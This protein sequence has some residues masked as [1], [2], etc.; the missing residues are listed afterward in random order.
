M[1]DLIVARRARAPLSATVPIAVADE[2]V[3]KATR[4]RARNRP[5]VWL[6]RSLLGVPFVFMG[7]ELVS[8]ALDPA[9]GVPLVADSANDVLGTSA[10]ILFVLMLTVTPLVTVTGWTWHRV[11]RRDFGLG[12]FA[13]AMT[14]LVLAATVS[15]KTFPGG[16]LTRVAGHT[17]LFVGTLATILLVPLALTANKRAQRWLGPHWK[18]LHRIVYAVWVLI[19]IHLGFLFGFRSFFIDS[20]LVSAPLALMRIPAIRDRWVSSRRAGTHRAIRWGAG[21]ALL[22][23]FGLGLVPFLHEIVHVGIGAFTETPPS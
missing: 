6:F 18:S 15:G 2:K 5:A 9:R 4:R 12:M 17:F 11:L 8:V 20:L 10:W 19:L 1:S 21:A 23:V 13:V 14:D 22:G 16:L 7:P 3:V